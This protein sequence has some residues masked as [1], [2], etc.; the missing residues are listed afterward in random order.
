MIYE[1]MLNTMSVSNIINEGNSFRLHSTMVTSTK[2][3]M[4]TFDQCIYEKYAQGLITKEAALAEMRDETI[5]AQ[6]KMLWAQNQ[7]Y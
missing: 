4:C 1:I 6:V 2:Q 3:G 5:I 7:Q